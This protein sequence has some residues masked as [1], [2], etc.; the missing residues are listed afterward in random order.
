MGSG[1][2]RTTFAGFSP[3]RS[4]APKRY[5]LLRSTVVNHKITLW[6]IRMGWYNADFQFFPAAG[7]GFHHDLVILK[8]AQVRRKGCPDMGKTPVKEHISAVHFFFQ[9]AP[10]FVGFIKEHTVAPP[11]PK[12]L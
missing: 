12:I 5:T 11:R 2:R 1:R 7:D 9:K 6:R 8:G 10:I 4:A 3:S